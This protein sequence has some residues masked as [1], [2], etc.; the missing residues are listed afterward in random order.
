MGSLT[1]DVIKNIIDR[2]FDEDI[3]EDECSSIRGISQK[4]TDD[5]CK[6]IREYFDQLKREL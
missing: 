5:L 4:Y 1:K 2:L 6:D 3:I